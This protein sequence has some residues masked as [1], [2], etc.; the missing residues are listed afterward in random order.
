MQSL[1]IYKTNNSLDPESYYNLFLLK[2]RHF[3]LDGF[4]FI[5][6]LIY[7]KIWTAEIKFHLANSVKL[8]DI[9]ELPCAKIILTMHR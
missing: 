9:L 6:W 4:L 7:H 3:T 5:L 1:I 8:V 2:S